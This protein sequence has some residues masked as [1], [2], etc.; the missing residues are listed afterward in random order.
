MYPQLDN[1]IRSKLRVRHFELLDVLGETLNI[2][3]AAPRLS[4]SQPAT[5]KLLHETENTLQNA[6]V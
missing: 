5:S 3:K 1:R 4:L 6:L 2:H